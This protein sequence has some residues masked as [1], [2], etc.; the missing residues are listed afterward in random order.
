MTDDRRLR[1]VEIGVQAAPGADPEI[2]WGAVMNDIVSRIDGTARPE[3]GRLLVYQDIDDLGRSSLYLS[4]G[5]LQTLVQ[6][7]RGGLLLREWVAPEDLPNACV[8]LL[9]ETR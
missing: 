8:C 3:H 1:R 7:G 9:D 5:A 6:S 4:V 2:A